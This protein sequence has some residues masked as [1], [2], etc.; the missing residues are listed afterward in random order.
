MNE[1]LV[2]YIHVL[3]Y[4]REGNRKEVAINLW[5]NGY[6]VFHE[7]TRLVTEFE[8]YKN[9]PT[10]QDITPNVEDLAY[11]AFRKTMDYTQIITCFENFMKGVLLLNGYVVHKISSKQKKDL[12]DAQKDRPIKI[13]EV[14][15]ENSFEQYRKNDTET[16]K[17]TIYFSWLLKEKYQKVIQLPKD[18]C[19]ILKRIN[20][21]RN[22]LHFMCQIQI[23]HTE[24]G[25]RDQQTLIDFVQKTIKPCMDSLDKNLSEVVNNNKVI[26]NPADK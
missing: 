16:T 3:A 24:Q 20:K 7:G 19:D 5:N 11:F 26:H 23:I 6:L 4:Y 1:E 18:V 8:K 17:E 10:S 12:S 13:E 21:E 9:I 2:R 15:T 25:I 22:E 14:F